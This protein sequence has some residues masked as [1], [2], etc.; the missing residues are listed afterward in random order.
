MC[1]PT[2]APHAPHYR[3]PRRFRRHLHLGG[4]TKQDLE[5]VPEATPPSLEGFELSAEQRNR[6]ASLVMGVDEIDDAPPLLPH[7]KAV[8]LGS[9]DTV[10]HA[11][12]LLVHGIQL[13]IFAPRSG[14]G[15]A[16]SSDPSMSDGA[17]PSSPLSLLTVH[18]HRTLAKSFRGLVAE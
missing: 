17:M 12:H 2:P 3:H 5:A 15:S 4:G 1:T 9:A 14:G 16:R 13:R 10:E 6:V 8:R 7:H 11:L 18:C